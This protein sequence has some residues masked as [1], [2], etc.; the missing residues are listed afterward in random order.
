MI[1]LADLLLKADEFGG[2]SFIRPNGNRADTMEHFL[3]PQPLVEAVTHGD[4]A[5]GLSLG[6][7]IDR[8]ANVFDLVA[9]P[10]LV[11]VQGVNLASVQVDV[12]D[13]HDSGGAAEQFSGVP[14][15]LLLRDGPSVPIE[16]G[17][18]VQFAPEIAAQP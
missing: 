8:C 4:P 5:I 1:D 13:A 9:L 6:G 10:A 17:G 14:L 11:E 16:M 7:K 15:H 18:I 2:E 12:V 3:F